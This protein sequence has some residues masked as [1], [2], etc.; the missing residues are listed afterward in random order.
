MSLS[1]LLPVLVILSSAVASTLVFFMNDEWGRL[2]TTVYLGG[3]VIKLALVLVMLRGIYLG[4]SYETRIPLVPGVDF[5]LRANPLAMLFLTLSAGLWLLTTLYSI[6]YLRNAPHRSR[7]FGFFG[8]S[9]SAT[10]GIALAGNPL[11]FFIF[12]EIL[13]LATYPLVV[14]RD[15]PEA[16]AAG[17]NYLAYTLAGGV[18]L[19]AGIVG[20]HAVAGP[21][22]FVTGGALEGTEAGRGALIAVF[23]LLIAGLGVKTALVPLHSWL[24]V[25]MV[26]PTPVSALLHGVAVVKAGAFGVVRV[27]YEVFGIEFSRELGVTLPLALIAAAT[28]IYGSVR[29]LSQDELKRMLAYS[30]VSQ[31]S[32]IVLGVALAGTLDSIGGIVHLVHQGIMKVTLFF[33]AGVVAETLGIYRISEMAGV[34]RRLPWTMAAFA[35]GAFGMMGLPP[36]AGFISKWY[37]GVGA[38]DAG[39]PWAIAVLATSTLLNAA[40]FLPVIYAAWLKKPL[41]EWKEKRAKTRFEADWLLLFPTLVLALFVPAAGLLAGL[42]FSPLAWARLIAS[43]EWGYEIE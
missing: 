5:L 19:L 35:V 25:A 13:T 33:C 17:Y 3:E 31:V 18:V 6:G 4:E 1:A 16:L 22:E 34:A 15:T 21:V 29:A 32:Y 12:Y 20:L 38:V 7:F 9:V 30:T 27:V 24:P 36:M 43:R 41:G 14:H 28:I 37:L 23:A 8:L 11:T 42:D 10:A 40:Y 26:A 2:R 39:Q